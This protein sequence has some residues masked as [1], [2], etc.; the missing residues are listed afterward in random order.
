MSIYAELLSIKQFR[1]GKA[2]A[3]VGRARGT[4]AQRHR[5]ADAARAALQ[6]WREEA[7]ARERAWYADLCARIVRLRDIEEVQQGVVGLRATER[8]REDAERAAQRQLEESRAALA[9]AQR[10]HAEA[11]RMRDKFA[12]LAEQY[13]GELAAEAERKEDLEMEEAA[14]VARDREE[15]DE[16]EHRDHD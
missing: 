7:V 5:D 14:S 1:E 13:A 9:S 6:A 2:A 4:L 16:W 10:A 8:E 3:E 11:A 15:F 12:E